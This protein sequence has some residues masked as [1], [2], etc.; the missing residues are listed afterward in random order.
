MPISLRV[1]LELIALILTVAHA[2]NQRVPLWVP[3]FVLCVAL[4]LP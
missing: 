1:L 3:L 2:A 4:L